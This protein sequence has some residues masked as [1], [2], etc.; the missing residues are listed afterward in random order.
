VEEQKAGV[1][2]TLDDK[3]F[4]QFCENTARE[5]RETGRR[6]PS[7]FLGRARA[8]LREIRNCHSRAAGFVQTYSRVPGELEW[9]LD[10]WYI[11]QREGK[12]GIEAMR[13]G[14]RLRSVR[15]EGKNVPLIYDL[16]AE[17]LKAEQDQVGERRIVLFLESVQ[18][19][20]PLTERELFLF[21]PALRLAL[22]DG[23]ARTCASLDEMMLGRGRRG[24]TIHFPPNACCSARGRSAA[25]FPPRR[26]R[27]RNTP[28]RSTNS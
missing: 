3:H 5:Q 8:S 21:V 28:R 22:V 18:R 16:A 11:A 26:R 13:G 4:K 2:F 20:K 27:S 15:R 19:V 12:S 25:A 9:L 17:F 23:I 6:S 24:R 14:G 7:F 1:F 10:N